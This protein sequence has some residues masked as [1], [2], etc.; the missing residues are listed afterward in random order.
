MLGRLL[1][2]DMKAMGRILLP[3]YLVLIVLSVVVRFAFGDIQ[4]LFSEGAVFYGYI[5]ILKIVLFVVYIFLIAA[6]SITTIIIIIQ[7]FYKN[8]LGDEGYLM[9]TLPVKPWQNI[10][11]KLLSAF[12]WTFFSGLV[13]VLSVVIMVYEHTAFLEFLVEWNSLWEQLAEEIDVSKLTWIII[14]YIIA[15]FLQQFLSILLLYAS[16]AVGQLAN[17]HKKALS[18]CAFFGIYTAM[19]IVTSQIS[20]VFLFKY[21]VI[22]KMTEELFYELFNTAAILGIVINLV[23][24]GVLFFVTNYLVDKKLNLD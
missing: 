20:N 1:K 16:M 2:Y 8:I 12:L 15:C 4:Q 10:T 5:D 6:V 14:A 9:N 21:Y 18:V 24:I 11:A 22:T 3:M 7:R 17:V 19:S 13:S 23:V